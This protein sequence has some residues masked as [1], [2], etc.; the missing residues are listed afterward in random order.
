MPLVRLGPSEGL[1][2]AAAGVLLKVG[3][4]LLNLFVRQHFLDEIDRVFPVPGLHPEPRLKCFN[5]VGV[6]PRF[7]PDPGR[8]D[9]HLE[10]R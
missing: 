6:E 4:L 10:S 8:V 5:P 2:G 7:R 9:Q 1:P 3:G